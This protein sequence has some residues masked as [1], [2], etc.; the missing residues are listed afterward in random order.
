MSYEPFG[1]LF[2][3]P[4]LPF[5][6]DGSIDEKGY[7]SFIRRF[8][9]PQYLTAGMAIIATLRPESCSRLTMKSASK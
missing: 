1:K 9:T 4:V 8:L 5:L 3:T 2:V 7:R 6:E